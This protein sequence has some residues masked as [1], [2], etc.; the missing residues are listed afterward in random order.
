MQKDKFY[1]NKPFHLGKIDSDVD[2][3]HHKEKIRRTYGW[4]CPY[5]DYK[6]SRHYN[7]QRHIYLTHGIGSGEPVDH[8]TGE[9]REEKRRAANESRNQPMNMSVYRSSHTISPTVKYPNSIAPSV[10]PNPIRMPYLEAQEMRARELGY[11][12]GAQTPNKYPTTPSG[13][14]DWWNEMNPP[15]RKNLSIDFVGNKAGPYLSSPTLKHEPDYPLEA[16]FSPIN[17]PLAVSIKILL[18]HVRLQK[19]FR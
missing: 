14:A 17:G 18:D 6:S 11:P 3:L 15:Y 13:S 7:T 2:S 4:N 10:S 12:I 9:T 16:S 1:M 5:Q 8:M 19:C